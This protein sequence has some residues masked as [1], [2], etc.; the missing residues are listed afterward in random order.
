MRSLSP[1]FV[2][3]FCQIVFCNGA[4]TCK[5]GVFTEE[6]DLAVKMLG[7]EK[8]KELMKRPCE[9]GVKQCRALLCSSG[10]HIYNSW[11]CSDGS[12]SAEETANFHGPDEA[13]A[14]RHELG[15]KP[16]DWHCEVQFSPLVESRNEEL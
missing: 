7:A 2:L 6:G 12:M 4:L 3:L 8:V 9:R 10:K 15:L 16:E 11:D 13:N 1:I 14:F 5:R